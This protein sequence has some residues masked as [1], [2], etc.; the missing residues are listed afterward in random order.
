MTLK[1]I[2]KKDFNNSEKLTLKRFKSSKLLFIVMWLLFFLNYFFLSNFPDNNILLILLPI[3]YIWFITSL[4]LITY[5]SLK[6]KFWDKAKFTII[7]LII[8]WIILS[9][10]FVIDFKVL[11][12]LI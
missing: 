4:L 10:P 7:L 6:I 2:L 5:Y 3:I 8:M 1:D 11:S 12:N 9:V